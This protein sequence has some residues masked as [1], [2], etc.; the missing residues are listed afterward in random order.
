M[1]L[2]LRIE[3]ANDVGVCTNAKTCPYKH[4]SNHIAVCTHYLSP[5]GC[6]AEKCNLSHSATPENTPICTHFLKG[7]CTKENC[8]YMHVS[9]NTEAPIC[10]DFARNG[11]C[12]KGSTC[13]ERHLRECPAYSNYGE[14]TTKGCRLPHIARA[15]AH[16]V[17][18]P[19]STSAQDDA[20]NSDSHSCT[21]D[22]Y[23]SE[24]FDENAFGDFVKL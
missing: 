5:R 7:S 6:T 14:C 24:D 3:I 23:E 18:R 11:Y 2:S 17:Q 13:S 10:A 21:S 9:I 16:L 12:S 19:S 1:L 4:D 8:K 20:S 22:D 15:G